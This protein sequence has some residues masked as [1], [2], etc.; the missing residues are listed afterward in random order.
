MRTDLRQPAPRGGG[1]GDGGFAL[2]LVVLLLFAIGTIG[3]AGYRI[4]SSEAIQARQGIETVRALAVAQGGVQWFTARQRGLVPDSVTVKINGGTA[5]IGTRR[6]ASVSP[7]EDLYFITSEGSYSD[8]RFPSAPAVRTISQFAVLNNLPVKTM[9]PLVTTAPRLRVGG[10]AL[11]DG[12]DHAVPGQC[13]GAPGGPWA[14]VFGRANIQ[15]RDG[16]AI[17]GDPP[18]IALGS[19]ENVVAAAA[20]PWEVLTDPEFPVEYD[21]IWPNFA[22][23]GSDEFPVV[24][25]PGD[26]YPTPAESGQGVLIIAGNLGFPPG[27]MWEWKGIVL[28]GGLM[29][30]GPDANFSLEGM[31]AAGL[32][33]PMNPFDMEGG[34][35]LYHSCY[36]AWAGASLAHL[37]VL[38]GGWWEEF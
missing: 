10:S 17:I 16:G 35:I 22:S 27:S 12:T 36:V 28:A 31:L 6:I 1:R 29:P 30:S 26:F 5:V 18:A 34:R 23:L 33:N 32:G 38:P 8:P 9:A 4:I 24:R 11:V 14:G 19:F 20:V 15:T 7:S 25:V 37:S 2:G 3:A 21:G 13:Q